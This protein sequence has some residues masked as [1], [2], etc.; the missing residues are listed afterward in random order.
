MNTDPRRGLPSATER[1]RTT[2]RW[3]E[4]AETHPVQCGSGTPAGGE[5]PKSESPAERAGKPRRLHT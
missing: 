1:R 2:V 4:D 3:S 5:A